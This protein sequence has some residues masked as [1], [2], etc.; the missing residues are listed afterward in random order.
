M[1]EYAVHI[2]TTARVDPDDDDVW[3]ALIEQLE[4]YAAAFGTT[5]SAG[6]RLDAQMTV[7][8][9][10]LHA[11]GQSGSAAVLAALSELGIDADTVAVEVQTAAEFARQFERPRR[12]DDLIPTSEA[13]ELLGV[14][15]QRVLQLAKTPE[16]PPAVRLGSRWHW[17]RAELRRFAATWNRAPGPKVRAGVEKAGKA[18]RRRVAG[19]AAGNPRTA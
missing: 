4:P 8:A 7:E 18:G 10:S 1:A 16:F 5:G 15:R 9:D 19:P 11:A 17:S 2:T 14:S 3:D 6:D 12:A 13:A